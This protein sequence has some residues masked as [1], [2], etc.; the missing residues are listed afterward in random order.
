MPI[1]KMK[2]RKKL[3]FNLLFLY[4][5]VIKAKPTKPIANP[6]NIWITKPRKS[7]K[8]KETT[9]NNS[10]MSSISRGISILTFLVKEGIKSKMS[11]NTLTNK[12]LQ[13]WE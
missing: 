13:E 7:P 1:E 10:N 11:N 9:T 12:I 4:K 3:G 8:K 6:K 5:I 2:M